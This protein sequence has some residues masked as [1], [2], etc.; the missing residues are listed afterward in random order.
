MGKNAF[1]IQEVFFRWFFLLLSY[2]FIIKTP[3]A[4]RFVLSNLFHDIYHQT[5]WFFKRIVSLHL[6]SALY[7]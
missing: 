3:L 7:F 2:C 5:C 1:T 6:Y 4:P